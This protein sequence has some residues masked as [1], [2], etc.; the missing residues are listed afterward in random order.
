MAKGDF[1]MQEYYDAVQT[2]VPHPETGEAIDVGD[3]DYW[4][5]I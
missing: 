5:M 1:T 3:S 4:K 2:K